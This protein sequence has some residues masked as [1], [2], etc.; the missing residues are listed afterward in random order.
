MPFTFPSH[1]A[2]VIPIYHYRPKWFSITA[3]VVGSAAPDLAFMLYVADDLGHRLSG[4]VLVCLPFGVIFTVW[5]EK[6]L[7]P[8]LKAKLPAMLFINFPNM[9]AI[10]RPK[11]NVRE[12]IVISYSVL[13]GTMTHLLLDGLSHDDMWLSR[14]IYPKV[15]IHM[16][17]RYYS[18]ETGV[19]IIFT[20]AGALIV[21]RYLAVRFPSQVFIKF[22]ELMPFVIVGAVAIITGTL[23]AFFL[24]HSMFLKIAI[25]RSVAIALFISFSMWR[26]FLKQRENS[27][28]TKG[29]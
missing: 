25:S 27:L 23:W 15:G 26:L 1:A 28:F 10:E 22:R 19:W 24:D 20:I 29:K 9:L 17:E 3:L 4:A 7:V 8:V 6:V 14:H 11:L 21:W 12:I 18:I 5:V 13:I 16:F 2:A